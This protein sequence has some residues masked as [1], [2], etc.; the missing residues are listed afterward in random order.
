MAWAAHR[1]TSAGS[2]S[3]ASMDSSSD[4]SRFCSA[5]AARTRSGSL[6]AARSRRLAR[7]YITCAFSAAVRAGSSDRVTVPPSKSSSSTDASLRWTLWSCAMRRSASL[8]SRTASSGA[9]S[10][11]AR[12]R[13]ARRATFSS[14]A[15]S[16]AR[17][18][19]ATPADPAV[20]VTDSNAA[21]S[22]GCGLDATPGSGSGY[23]SG[24]SRSISC[25]EASGRA[26]RAA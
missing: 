22:E 6:A 11:S 2:A 8:R 19:G 21:S 13:S 9:A 3:P 15:A 18:S 24:D 25:G 16:A 12:N 14:S 1:A 23:G 26:A 5:T 10:A 7:S 4:S 20:D 17:T